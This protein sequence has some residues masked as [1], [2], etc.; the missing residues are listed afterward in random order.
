MVVEC[1]CAILSFIICAVAAVRMHDKI[2]FTIVLLLE[3]F[4]SVVI[5][6]GAPEVGAEMNGFVN[7]TTNY[8]GPKEK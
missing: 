5:K 2:V 7:G 8:P 4:V 6:L 1:A 3:E